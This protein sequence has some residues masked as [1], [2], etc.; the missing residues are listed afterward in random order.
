MQNQRYLPMLVGAWVLVSVW[1]CLSWKSQPQSGVQ[2][3]Y[4]AFVPGQVA[5]LSCTEWPGLTE[6]LRL[7][8]QLSIGKRKL[9]EA[10]DA[11]VLAG[12]ENQPYMM[13]FTPAAV[14]KLLQKQKQ[15][16][17][18]RL[19]PDI[20]L[21]SVHPSKRETAPF[22]LY[23]DSI[24]PYA[25]WQNWLQQFSVWT[26]YADAV[27]IPFVAGIRQEIISDRG[28]KVALREAEA[29]WLLIDT[30]SGDLIWNGWHVARLQN[31]QIYEDQ[32]PLFPEW[33]QLS[34]R[35]LSPSLWSEY[36]GRV[37]DP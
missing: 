17:F 26:R 34:Y 18:L 35:L 30:N 3:A 27:L 13:G 7:H 21:Q 9:C 10:M 31:R 25:K 33:R 22:S 8:S 12:F 2:P 24:A 16:A 28:Q 23:Q 4:R 6:S 19:W 15:S 5:L 29:L 20:W 1:G 36:P 32:P 11:F 14:E 37:V